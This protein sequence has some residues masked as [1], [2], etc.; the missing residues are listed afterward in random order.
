MYKFIQRSIVAPDESRVT[1]RPRSPRR[2]RMPTSLASRN[3]RRGVTTAHCAKTPRPCIRN[4]SGWYD[5]NPANLSIRC[6]PV[7]KPRKSVEYMGGADAVI[8]RACTDFAKAGEYRWVATAMNQVVFADPANRA[9]RE[10]GADALEQ[11]GFQ[12][13]FAARRND[14]SCRRDGAAQRRSQGCRGRHCE[15][16]YAGADRSNEQYFDYL[17]VRL[18]AARPRARLSQRTGKPP[19]Q[20][21]QIRDVRWRTRRWTCVTGKCGTERRCHRH[22][23][24]CARHA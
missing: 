18:N 17:G 13:E 5:A 7:E 3:G 1:R 8:A 6:P 15:S 2:L 9:A 16:R 10:L 20:S 12:A 11:L 14:L 22:Q 23:R 24:A 21:Q 4:I 19:T